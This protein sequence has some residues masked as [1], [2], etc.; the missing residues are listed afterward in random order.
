MSTCCPVSHCFTSARPLAKATMQIN[1][2]VTFGNTPVVPSL[3][4][5]RGWISCASE[6]GR[7]GGGLNQLFVT[8]TGTHPV[9]GVAGDDTSFRWYKC[10]WGLTGHCLVGKVGFNSS[11]L[12]WI[13]S[14]R[15]LFSALPLLLGRDTQSPSRILVKYVCVEISSPVRDLHCVSSDALWDDR[16]AVR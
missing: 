1:F 7:G 11:T 15:A 9:M 8:R 6:G 10:F 4:H 16:I 3:T 5:K 2:G 12:V 13:L 14:A